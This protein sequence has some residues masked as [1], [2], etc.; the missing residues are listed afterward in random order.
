MILSKDN[1][2]HI[3]AKGLVV[4]DEKLFDLPEKVLQ[5]GTGVLLRG[6]PDYFIDQANRK[7]VFNGRI[8]IVKS[9]STTGSIGFEQQD[10]LYT[11]CV[12]GFEEG[13]A[14]EENIIIS[15]VSRVIAAEKDWNAVLDFAQQ[16]D[17]E[18]VVSNTTEVGISLLN[19]S[20]HLQPPISFP[21][22]LL[23][24]L[25]KRYQ[26][27]KG[28]STA[29][30]V[31]I[32]TELISDNGK[33]L[34]GIVEELARFNKLEIDFMQWM[35]ANVEF[36][37]SLVDRIV[38]GGPDKKIQN[39]LE[40]QFGYRDQLLCIAE[41]YRLWAIE[42]STKA[43]VSLDFS[44]V[45]QG[46]IVTHDIE[47]FKELKVRLL[48]GT[49]TLSC[50]IAVLA[51]ID[52]VK[53]GMG[54]I[55]LKQ[56]ISTLMKQ[57]IALG[58]PYPIAEKVALEFADTV[59]DR[60]ANP[61]IE[62]L[63]I[64][65]TVQYTMKM[66]IRVLPVLLNYYRLYD[67]VPKHI[68]FGFAAFLHFMRSAKKEENYFGNFNDLE[69]RINDDHAVYFYQ[70]TLSVSADEQIDQVVSGRKYVARVLND[71]EFWTADL[72]MLPGF[73]AAVYADYERILKDG[74]FKALA[75]LEKETYT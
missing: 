59:L 62:H 27:F 25:Y 22:K 61:Y 60:F 70:K 44:R 21:A 37:N 55:L 52:T 68:A 26:T 24:V 66:K 43:I 47:Q 36:C 16:P 57:E 71:S 45:C 11:L 69:Y 7:G 23:A 40:E 73:T 50:G 32:A 42:G 28:S 75:T 5:F 3:K 14:V 38:P 34:Q 49:H 35:Q 48:N 18:L 8:V 56:Y 33:K 4:P 65:I 20:I 17:L 30:L 10:N 2:K 6:L 9:T 12:R 63:W 19:E 41:P 58:I 1:L 39:N 13:K 54:N 72:N 15:A 53:N 74:L 64:N 46:M 31:V 67:T 51:G 29:G